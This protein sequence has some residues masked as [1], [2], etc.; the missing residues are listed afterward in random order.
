MSD[1]FAFALFS[2][3]GGFL[4]GI[5]LGA[6]LITLFG[7]TDFVLAVLVGVWLAAAV[8]GITILVKWKG[9]Q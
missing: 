5:P 3:C 1:R 4:A 8:A 2:I 7:P 6:G 9:K